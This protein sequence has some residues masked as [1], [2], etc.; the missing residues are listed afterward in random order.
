MTVAADHAWQKRGYDSLTGFFF[1]T[2]P[3]FL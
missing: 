1:Q 3:T 2:I